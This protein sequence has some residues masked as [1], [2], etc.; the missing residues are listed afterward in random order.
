MANAYTGTS[1]VGGQGS[2]VIPPYYADFMREN[3][4][5]NMYFRQIGNR[6]VIPRGTG[7]KVRIPKW[8]SPLSITAGVTGVGA[9][10]AICAGI[11][12]AIDGDN[13]ATPWAYSKSLSA[14]SITGQVVQY[15]GARGYSD[16]LILVSRGNYIEG[17]LESLAREQ[18]FKI[19]RACRLG[20]TANAAIRNAG[21]TTLKAKTTDGLFAKNVAKIPA[22]FDSQN[23]ARYNGEY[24][25]LLSHTLAQFDFFSDLSA[26]GF[27]QVSSY[28]NANKIYR[29]EVGMM[30]GV[31]VLLTGMIPKV[32]AVAATSA[33]IGLSASSTG[34]GA[35]AFAQDAF[36]NI[37]LQGGGLEVVHQPL[38]S[39]GAISDPLALRGTIGVKVYH[40]LAVSPSAEQRIMRFGHGIGL[41][42]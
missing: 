36:W 8:D 13:G 20:L 12:G 35:F 9:N 14:S 11:Q 39:S 21:A 42:Y 2:H 16:R 31:R 30:Y 24:Y 3:L 17:A 28:Q 10:S 6:V 25:V 27:V 5:P 37:E 18:A 19:D 29:G 7:Q 4:W 26:N 22:Y 1:T 41:R 33:T 38:G 32:F 15:G 40:G 23:V 34:V